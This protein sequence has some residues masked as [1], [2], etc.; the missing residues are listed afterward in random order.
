[1]KHL[2]GTWSIIACLLLPGAA[3]SDPP[4]ADPACLEAEPTTDKYQYLRSLSVALRGTPPSLD[5]YE[6]LHGLDDVPDAWIDDWLNSVAFSQQVS[7]FHRSLLWNRVDNRTPYNHWGIQGGGPG[8][9]AATGYH[10]QVIYRGKHVGCLD[11][12]ATFDANGEIVGFWNEALQATQEGYVM[13]AP[14]WD[15]E[16]PI[17]VC[18]YNAQTNLIS[19]TGTVCGTTESKVDPKCGCGPNLIWCGPLSVEDTVLKYLGQAV[20]K[21]IERGSDHYRCVETDASGA[22][23]VHQLPL[24]E[25][26]L[27]GPAD[28]ILAPLMA[29][30]GSRGRF[31]FLSRHGGEIH[32]MVF[33][34]LDG[35]EVGTVTVIR[36]Q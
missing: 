32:E 19:P 29:V 27:L 3:Q 23:V 33:E 21:T 2:L 28:A 15:P 11:E 36:S 18:A 24:V 13:V 5:E 20:E 34:V 25:G 8:Q 4:P 1:M 26:L 16:N 6:A 17:K 9:P 31:T 10:L 35:D 22:E 12:P 7:R 30:S 14:Y